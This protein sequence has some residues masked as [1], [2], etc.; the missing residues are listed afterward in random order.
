MTR[1]RAAAEKN[2]KS[3]TGPR[4]YLLAA[5]SGFLLTLAFPRW[6]LWPLAWVGLIPLFYAL[7]QARKRWQAFLFGFTAGFVF[8]LLSISW[9]RHVTLFGLFF[10]VAI[11]AVYW[12]IFGWAF[13][14]LTV[15]LRKKPA[16]TFLGLA[17]VWVALELIRAEIPVW[18]FGWNLLGSSQAP[19]LWIAQLASVGGVYA[20]SFLV[21]LGNRVVYSLLRHG[22]KKELQTVLVFSL[23]LAATALFGWSRI[24]TFIPNSLFRVSV[25]QGNIPQLLKWEQAYKDE[26]L[27]IY[28][29]LTELASYD[30]P[31]LIVWPEAAYPGFFNREPD[32]ERIK[33][34][35]R[36]IEVPVLVGSPHQEDTGY[37]NSAYLLNPKGEVAGRYDKI[38][39]VPFG[40]YIPWKPIFGFLERYA[41][42]LG[43]SDFSAGKEFTVFQTK[44]SGPKFSILVCFEDTFP[45]LARTLVE[46]G[47]DF[48]GVLTNDA[49][50]GHSSAPYQ[51][52]QASVFRAIENGVP[53][54]RAANTGVSAFITPRGIVAERVKNQEGDDSWVMGGA[55]YPVAWV[56]EKTFYR[57]GGWIFPYVCFVALVI[58]SLLRMKKFKKKVRAHGRAP[59]LFLVLTAFSVVGCIRVAGGAYY[60]KKT[61]DEP[62]QV[63]EVYVDTAELVQKQAPGSITVD[64]SQ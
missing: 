49:W 42:A 5:L 60:A 12:G 17:A 45:D 4:P 37:T 19:N 47:A 57:Q 11:E 64:E 27:R 3:A 6:G 9:L 40:E 14:F 28:L 10:V 30:A 18:G 35:V 33:E 21:F 41:Y 44:E 58:M 46:R 16:P 63:K 2:I 62:P 36:K 38:R 50:F 59:L 51:H 39:L 52:L 23:L 32:A 24:Q 26:I 13:H 22:I 1:A 25:L 34:L 53:V 31:E 20:V 56:R 15:R 7:D 61:E 29:N 43:V 55:T 54:F 48:L 8:F